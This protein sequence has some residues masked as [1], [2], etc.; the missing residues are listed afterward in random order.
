MNII[1][2]EFPDRQFS[3]KEEMF[4]SL[5]EN[6]SFLIAQKKSITKI[7][8]S[9]FC[10]HFAE[11]VKTAYKESLTALANIDTINVSLAI[12]SCNIYDSHGDV[13][14]DGTWNKSAKESKGGLLLNAHRMTFDNII[15]DGLSVS[16]KRMPWSKLGFD[17]EGSTDV[18]VFS[19]NISK[20]RNEYMF[21]Q[22]SKGYVKEH[23]VGMRY[24]KIE[25]AIN[26]DSKWDEE[27]KEVW[28]KYYQRIVNKDAVDERGYFWAVTEAKIVEGSAVVK[29]SNY[30]TPVISIEAVEN[31]TSENKTEPSKDT[32]LLD[33]LKELQTKLN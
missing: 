10:E 3:S 16:V 33:A 25:L 12:N 27:E 1:I 5:R 4:K 22:Y 18:L 26:S 7:A 20:D 29:G 2:K 23:S 14:F 9:V 28:D 13:H 17:F 24:V 15:A 11:E 6:K 19:G 8:D 32:P 21:K 30:A 31:D